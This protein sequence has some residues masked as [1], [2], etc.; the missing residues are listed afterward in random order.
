MKTKGSATMKTA[1]QI[2]IEIIRKL[3]CRS[4]ILTGPEIYA[5]QRRQGIYS[6][7]AVWNAVNEHTLERTKHRGIYRSLIFRQPTP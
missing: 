3:A 5:A 4:P 6:T 7:Y 2:G 1:H